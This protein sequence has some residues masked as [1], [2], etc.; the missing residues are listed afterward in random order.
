MDLVLGVLFN[1]SGGLFVA[2][3]MFEMVFAARWHV[4]WLGQGVVLYRRTVDISSVGRQDVSLDRLLKKMDSLVFCSFEFRRISVGL[5]GFRERLLDFAII[6]P[7]IMHG[8]LK[9]EEQKGTISVEGR[10]YW[11][12]IPFVLMLFCRFLQFEVR[13]ETGLIVLLHLALFLGVVY[14]IQ[15]LR[16]RK[17]VIDLKEQV[18]V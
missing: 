13:E 6:Y 3:L 17:I 14:S 2:V 8:L 11:F 7:Q 18:M 9:F 15:C 16:Y 12:W 4:G 1:I 10:L 5:T